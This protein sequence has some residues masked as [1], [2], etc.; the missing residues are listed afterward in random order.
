MALQGKP[1]TPKWPATKRSLNFYFPCQEL[2]ALKNTK[3]SHTG[4]LYL[5]KWCQGVVVTFKTTL[6]KK[7]WSVAKWFFN[8]WV[9]VIHLSSFCSTLLLLSWRLIN[10]TYFDLIRMSDCMCF[11]NVPIVNV[12][13]THTEFRLEH[14]QS[15]GEGP[16]GREG[17]VTVNLW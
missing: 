16:P 13:H 7:I 8:D 6:I 11:V 9:L 4:T 14:A 2:N 3:P 12:T 1:L 10:W 5:H 15:S 17:I